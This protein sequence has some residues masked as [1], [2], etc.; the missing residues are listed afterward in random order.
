MISIIRES[1]WADMPGLYIVEP[2][3]EW[4]YTSRKQMIL[5][6]KSYDKQIN[7]Q[8]ILCGQKAYGVIILRSSRKIDEKLFKKLEREHQVT[9]KEVKKWWNSY[10]LYAYTFD[11]YPFKKPVDYHR[12]RGIQTMIKS[13][14]FLQQPILQRAI[15]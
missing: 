8:L 5:K 14:Q 6:R 15:R 10:Y 7:K 3:A 1:K 11:F 4:I 2:S 13:V 12:V 9:D